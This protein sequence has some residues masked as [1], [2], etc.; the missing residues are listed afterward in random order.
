VGDELFLSVNRRHCNPDKVDL[1]METL[2]HAAYRFDSIPGLGRSLA[3]AGAYSYNIY[4]FHQPYVMY[5]GEK[6]R[7]GSLGVLS[8]RIP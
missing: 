8:F 6:L 7:P 2:I 1:A 4:I 3:R 5:V